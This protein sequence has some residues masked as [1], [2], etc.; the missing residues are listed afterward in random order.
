M[1][2]W[3]LFTFE[4]SLYFEYAITFGRSVSNSKKTLHT[5]P[6]VIS[7][8]VFCFRIDKAGRNNVL[9][10]SLSIPSGTAIRDMEKT[11]IKLI[12]IDIKS[13]A[14]IHINL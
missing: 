10:Y 2:P 7:C 12:L 6:N 1:L 13:I 14:I 5:N 8:K 3:Q 4:I 9:W 11:D